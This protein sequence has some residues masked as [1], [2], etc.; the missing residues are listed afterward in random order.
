MTQLNLNNEKDSKEFYEVRYSDNYMEEWPIEK[1]LRIIEIIKCLNLPSHGDALDFGCGN[2]VF[3]DV[4]K[5]ALPHWH[6]YGCDISE[7]AIK[8]AAKRFPECTFFTNDDEKHKS[9]KFDFVFTHHVLEH[10]FD[11]KE[12][13]KQI[14]G[15]LK[16]S[17]SMLHIFPCG[18]PDSYEY[19]LCALRSDGIDKKTENRFFFEDEGHIRRMTT[20][21]C[22]H[23][24]KEYDFTLKHDYYSNQYYGAVNW[25]TQAGERL[26]LKMFNPIKGKDWKSKF[27]LTGMLLKMIF[28]SILRKPSKI[29][30]NILKKSV[31]QIQHLLF[32]Y[33]FYIPFKIVKSFDDYLEKKATDEWDKIKLNKN[34]SEMYLYFARKP[35][36]I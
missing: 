25:I 29:Y 33:M 5:K 6:I 18:N 19:R 34:G 30:K 31:K 35:H 22:V 12:L 10:V 13:A 15:L 23:L 1:K 20:D 9:K 32:I 27:K 4:L 36:Q 28:I 24:F 2:G 16:D 11:I 17:S 26:I 21:Q 14:N 7:T 8:N 3:S